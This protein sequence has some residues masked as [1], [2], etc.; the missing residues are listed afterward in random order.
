M[1]RVV[2]FG[3]LNPGTDTRK[4]A[5]LLIS[6]LDRLGPEVPELLPVVFGGQEPEGLSH[7][8]IRLRWLDEI[9]SPERLAQLYSAADVMVVPSRQD[10]LPQIGTEAQACGVPVVA[11][12]TAGLPDVVEDRRTGYLAEPFSTEDL[13]NGIRWALSDA[14]GGAASA[15]AR[16]RAERLWSSHTVAHEYADLYREAIDSSSR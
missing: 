14:H 9:R 8:R 6:A 4:G 1:P 16:A 2:L 15:N 11:F 10:N 3:A 7:P 13:A 12:R 5:D